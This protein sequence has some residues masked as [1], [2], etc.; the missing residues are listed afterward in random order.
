MRPLKTAAVFLFTLALSSCAYHSPVQVLEDGRYALASGDATMVVDAFHGGKVASL[1][2]SSQ[3]ILSQAPQIQTGS[4]FWTSPQ[5]VWNWPPIPEMDNQ[6]FTVVSIGDELVLRSQLSEKLPLRLEKIYKAMDKGAFSIT[7]SLEN[8]SSTPISVAPWEITRVPNDGVI[9]FDAPLESVT[10]SGLMSFHELFGALWYE[11]DVAQ[12]SR[13]IN[14][15][16]S[17]WLAYKNDNFLFLKSFPDIAQEQAAPNEAEVEVYVHPGKNY[18]EL[19]NQGAYETLEPGASLSWTVIWRL[20]PMEGPA[21][22]SER[23]LE[24]VQKLLK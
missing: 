13:K 4:I 22:A 9:F 16:G 17:G 8:A 10:P 1:S 21:V 7:Y 14:A 12:K 15:D 24:A 18:I 11:T 20:L 19:E 3:E 6:P 5:A 2:C 23:L